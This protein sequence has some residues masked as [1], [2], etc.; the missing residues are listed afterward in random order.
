[1]R[2]KTRGPW[3]VAVLAIKGRETAVVVNVKEPALLPRGVERV[4]GPFY[5]YANVLSQ[6]RK[7]DPT[8]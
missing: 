6:L 4:Y 7:L 3:I 8:F 2:R 1:M 5:K